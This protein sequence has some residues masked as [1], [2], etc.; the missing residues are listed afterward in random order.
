[1]SIKDHW[2]QIYK[3]RTSD[4]RSWH[5]EHLDLSLHLIGRANLPLDAAIVDIGGGSSTLVDDLLNLKYTNV[6]VLDISGVALQEAQRRLGDR[7]RD[8]VWIEGDA[9]MTNLGEGIVDLWHDRAVFHFMTEADA[10]AAYIANVF[11]SVKRNGFVVLA[12]F[13]PEG[14]RECSGLPVTRYD[15]AAL[16]K[17]FPGFRL[18]EGTKELHRTPWGRVQEFTY[19][20]MQRQTD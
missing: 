2:E 10:R 16:A 4:K 1:M 5:R 8:V 20:L 13:A 3:S 17:L 18:L 14:P 9:T 19:V 15:D 7:S 11:R 6:R 12:T